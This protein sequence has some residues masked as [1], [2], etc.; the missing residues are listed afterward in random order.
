MNE[1]GAVKKNVEI[2]TREE[3][4]DAFFSLIPDAMTYM[5]SQN[6]QVAIN[7]L[8]KALNKVKKDEEEKRQ[9]IAREKSEKEALQRYEAIKKAEEKRRQEEERK[10]NLHIKKV[11][12]MDLPDDWTNCFSLDEVV[13]TTSVYE[14]LDNSIE[15]LGC[16]N[17]E[18]IAASTG[19]SINDVISSLSDFIIQNPETWNECFYK[20]WE[21]KE[22]YL[23]GSLSQKLRVAKEANK[24]YKG[25]FK[26]NVKELESH[27]PSFSSKDIIEMEVKMQYL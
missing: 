2:S 14:S 12:S 20:G 7:S 19:M 4:V 24:K 10:E 26:R 25:Y 8:E 27:I 3:Y 5:T 22:D 13:S 9:R 18:Y 16:I 6:L 23:S 17:I 15:S 1:N 11:T 21:L